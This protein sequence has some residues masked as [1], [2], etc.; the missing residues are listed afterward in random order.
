[1]IGRAIFWIGLVWLFI[2]HE[3]NVGFDSPGIERPDLKQNIVASA[4]ATAVRLDRKCV[5]D[6]V[7]CT[8]AA[9]FFAA[10]AHKSHT[11][12]LAQVKAEIEVSIRAR[13]LQQNGGAQ[14]ASG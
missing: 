2:P 12:T 10:I 14:A 1:M 6:G 3:P 7:A 4:H 8:R 11:R 5:K 9:Q 13:K